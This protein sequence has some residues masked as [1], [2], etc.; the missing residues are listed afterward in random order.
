[1]RP[2]LDVYN[3]LNAS[4]VIN[5]NVT[6]GSAWKDATQILTGRLLR[7]GAQFDF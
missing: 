5:M 7:L 4:N 3:L 1:V 6:Y 2:S